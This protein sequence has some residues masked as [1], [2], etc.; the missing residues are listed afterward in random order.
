MKQS[1]YQ[2]G[3]CVRYISSLN[4]GMVGEITLVRFWPDGQP[5][6]HVK[7]DGYSYQFNAQHDE[8][9]LEDGPA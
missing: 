9:E 7:V 4:E 1:V 2:I 5:A 8:L 3:D 6:Y